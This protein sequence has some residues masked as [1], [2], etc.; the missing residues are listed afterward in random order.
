VV[1]GHSLVLPWFW[2][3]QNQGKHERT[4]TRYYSGSRIHVLFH[5]D[6][7]VGSGIEPDLLTLV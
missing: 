7:T 1:D 4:I 6:Y 5:P 2:F 3:S